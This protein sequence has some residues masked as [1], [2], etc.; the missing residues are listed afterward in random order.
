MLSNAD[1]LW[2]IDY[3]DALQFH[4]ESNSTATIV[5]VDSVTAVPYGVVKRDDPI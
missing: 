3:L 2:D 1:I 5:K 4:R